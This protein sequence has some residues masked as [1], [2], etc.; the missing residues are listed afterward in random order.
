MAFPSN[1]GARQASL[2]VAWDSAR[3]L[4]EQ[5]K[6]QCAAFVQ[7]SS[8]GV[9]AHLAVNLVFFLAS[10]RASLVAYSSVSGIGPYV[11]S[12]LDDPIIDI[13]AEFAALLGAIDAAIANALATFPKDGSDYLLFVKFAAG[14]AQAYRQLTAGQ[15]A[16]FRSAVSSIVAAID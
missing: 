8:G 11:K 9:S 2:S 12:Q 1:S 6:N 14:G 3:V 4:V 10:A 16:S 15:V 7:Q 13:G 5:V